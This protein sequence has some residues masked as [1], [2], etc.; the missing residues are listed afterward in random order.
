MIALEETR[1]VVALVSGIL[2][3]ACALASIF[4]MAENDDGTYEYPLN[5]FTVWSNIL[6]AVA[7]A[8]DENFVFLMDHGDNPAL[9]FIWDLSGGTGGI[10]YIIGL[11]LLVLAIFHIV[12]GI[13]TAVEK[14]RK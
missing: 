7:A 4:V 13:I 10:S 11:G 2:V 6:S 1:S 8:F 12:Y 14:I 5:Y 3:F 9:K